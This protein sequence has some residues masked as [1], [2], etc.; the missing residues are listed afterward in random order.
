MN[1]ACRPQCFRLRGPAIYLITGELE[2]M[3]EWKKLKHTLFTETKRGVNDPALSLDG[4]NAVAFLEMQG[5]S[6]TATIKCAS[7]TLTV[8]EVFPE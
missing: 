4:P 5:T 3:P 2:C 8:D 1:A 6:T 7:L